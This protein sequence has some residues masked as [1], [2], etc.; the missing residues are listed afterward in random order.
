MKFINSKI[1]HEFVIISYERIEYSVYIIYCK[2]SISL[3]YGLCM[4]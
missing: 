1:P 2:S 4:M 3:A